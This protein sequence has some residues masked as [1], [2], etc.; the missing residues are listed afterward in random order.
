[1]FKIFEVQFWI[2]NLIKIHDLCLF[3]MYFGF[4]HSSF[5]F[6]GLMFKFVCLRFKV[7]NCVW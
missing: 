6:K 5:R 4:K 3:L 2:L 7:S 1:M